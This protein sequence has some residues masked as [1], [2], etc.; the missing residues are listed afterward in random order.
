MTS[1][2]LNCDLGEG[3]AHDEALMPLITSANIAC[4]G[5]AGDRD[6][7]RV[8]VKLA[9]T[10]GVAVGAHPG[11]GDREHFGR[12]ELSLTT[13]EIFETVRDQIA[14]MQSIAH[15]LEVPL[16]HVKPHGALY[17]QAAKDREIAEAVVAAIKA[18]DGKLRLF[19]LAGS[20]LILAGQDGGLRV[21]NEVFVDRT[22]RGDGSL[23]P[24]DERGALI[25]DVATGVSQVMSMLCDGVVPTI[26]GT[27][28][29]LIADTICVHGDGDHAVDYA[30]ELRAALLRAGVEILPCVG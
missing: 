6:S 21:A 10:Y 17:T 9:S 14:L 7:M 16:T 2:D 20:E 1:I 23:T 24:R 25:A 26:E 30:R 12:R 8:T 22:Y 19:A 3:A 18:V 28:V 11:Y 27:H 29:P 4:G 13:N 15:E 5:H